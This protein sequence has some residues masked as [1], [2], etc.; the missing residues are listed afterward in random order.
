MQGFQ[1]YKVARNRFFHV[2][3]SDY[4]EEQLSREFSAVIKVIRNVLQSR[5]DSNIIAEKWKT[6]EAVVCSNP[7]ALRLQQKILLVALGNHLVEWCATDWGLDKATSIQRLAVDGLV[8]QRNRYVQRCTAVEHA[9]SVTFKEAEELAEL[10][11]SVK[12]ATQDLEDLERKGDGEAVYYAKVALHTHL[13]A[14]EEWQ[15]KRRSAVEDQQATLREL[16]T[17]IARL[18]RDIESLTALSMSRVKCL[19]EDT[20]KLLASIT[21]A[22]HSQV[23][24]AFCFLAPHVSEQFHQILRENFDRCPTTTT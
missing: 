19:A 3:D 9:T 22:D 10:E 18:D 23:Q 7:A 21:S 2:L 17:S 13:T 5:P 24:E 15:M 6:L 11:E 14:L 20:D 16:Q 1:E 12:E 8:T 4:S